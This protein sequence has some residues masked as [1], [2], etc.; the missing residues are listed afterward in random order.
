MSSSFQNLDQFIKKGGEIFHPG[1]SIDCVI[2]G[3]HG[4]QLKVLLLKMKH[5]D[6]WALPGGFILKNEHIDD[7]V[8]RICKERTGIDDIFLQQ[9]KIFGD[10]RR[11]S[12]DR[13]IEFVKREGVVVDPKKNWLL[14]RFLTIGYYALVEFSEV[15]PTADSLS[16]ACEWWDL[17]KNMPALIL[18]HAEILQ[19]ALQTLRL[20]LNHQPIGYNLLPQKFTMPELQKLYETILNKKLDR[21]NFQRRML[22][23]HILNRLKERRKGGAH[24]APYLYSFDLQKYHLALKQGLQWDW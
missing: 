4:T 3:F 24:K 11:S 19:E 17:K 8:N 6:N 14:Q 5:D 7:A 16:V 13:N 12:G 22:G 9:F 23:Y 1:L 15:S 2:F 18:D 10:P 20:Q 21:R